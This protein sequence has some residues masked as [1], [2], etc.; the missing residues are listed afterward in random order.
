MNKP[1]VLFPMK[2]QLMK[3]K[4]IRRIPYYEGAKIDIR[5]LI[6]L[7]EKIRMENKITVGRGKIIKIIRKPKKIDTKSQKAVEL[8][9]DGFLTAEDLSHI[10]FD[11]F[12]AIKY[13]TEEYEYFQIRWY[14]D[15]CQTFNPVLPVS[16][17]ENEAYQQYFTYKSGGDEED[18]KTA[19]S[20]FITKVG[21]SRAR[22][23]IL[24]KEKGIDPSDSIEN[25]MDVTAEKSF[26]KLLPNTVKLFTIKN[27]S[28]TNGIPF[29]LKEL[30]VAINPI[31]DNLGISLEELSPDS[32]SWI[33]DFNKA[34]EV[35][36]GVE[37]K[38]SNQV[39]QISTAD[40][41]MVVGFS[42][43][44][45]CDD[46][47]RE[48]F[49]RKKAAGAFE[50][51]KQDS[52]TNNSEDEM[53]GYSSTKSKTDEFIR[54]MS[55]ETSGLTAVNILGA[56]FGFDEAKKKEA[57]AYVKNAE[58]L[59][60]TYAMDAFT[61]IY[62]GC[63][64][65]FWKAKLEAHRYIQVPIIN[66]TAGGTIDITGYK[67]IVNPALNSIAASLHGSEFTIHNDLRCYV[68]AR[69]VIPPVLIDKNP[70][71]I[72]P[73]RSLPFW[74]YDNL[75]EQ[76][77]LS[78]S[79]RDLSD[80]FNRKGFEG[81]Y[82]G[83]TRRYNTLKSISD[84]MEVNTRMTPIPEK[85]YTRSLKDGA[86]RFANQE[87]VEM[88]MPIVQEG[89]LEVL[90]EC[91]NEVNNYFQKL[92][93]GQ[94]GVSIPII[95]DESPMD[96][97]SVLVAIV[98]KSLFRMKELN[99]SGDC[100]PRVL[101]MLNQMKKAIELL[102]S[103]RGPSLKEV[104]VLVKETLDIFS[105]RY[106]AWMLALSARRLLTTNREGESI[107]RNSLV[108]SQIPNVP[109]I[110]QN[111]TGVFGWLENP[112]NA[113]ST[114]N[115]D[116]YYQTPSANQTVAAAMI[117]N[118]SFY[119]EEGGNSFKVN[120]SSLRYKE[121][122]WFVEGLQKGF[123]RAELLGM[124]LERLLHD[125][126]LDRL[127]YK[128]RSYYPLDQASSTLKCSF[129]VNGEAFVEDSSLQGKGFSSADLSHLISL[130]R[131][132]VELNDCVT[133]L[134][135]SE[136]AYNVAAGNAEMANA[137]LSAFEN[138]LPAP[139]VGMAPTVRTGQA[140]MQRVIIPI[141]GTEAEHGEKNP[142][143]IAEPS[144][145]RL[146]DTVLNEFGYGTTHMK[147]SVNIRNKDVSQVTV[148]DVFCINPL[149]DLGLSAFD[150]V[151]GGQKELES[152][153]RKFILRALHAKG[154]DV[155][156]A[157]K[158]DN[159]ETAFE[160]KAY[161]LF[162]YVGGMDRILDKA[163]ALHMMIKSSKPIGWEDIAVSKVNASENFH[164]RLESLKTLFARL[165]RLGNSYRTELDGLVTLRESLQGVL[166]SKNI[167]SMKQ[168][169]QSQIDSIITQINTKLDLFVKYG[170]QEANLYIDTDV[171]SL[172][173]P[174]RPIREI[175]DVL[176][177][178]DR[179]PFVTKP[180]FDKPIHNIENTIEGKITDIFEDII[181]KYNA[182]IIQKLDLL[183]ERLRSRKVQVKLQETLKHQIS[184]TV[185]I[186]YDMQMD[187]FVSD[188]GVISDE[189]LKSLTVNALLNKVQNQLK[190]WTAGDAMTILP[191]FTSP[192][193]R[194]VM[195][196]SSVEQ[197]KTY[198]KVRKNIL[199]LVSL[200]EQFTKS[201][202]HSVWEPGILE[203]MEAIKSKI[204]KSVNSTNIAAVMNDLKDIKLD[205]RNSIDLHY[206]ITQDTFAFTAG[207]PFTG[208]KIDE[209]SDFIHSKTEVTGVGFKC[210]T[211][212]SQAPNAIL[213]AVP[214]YQYP[215]NS[216]GKWTHVHL[217]RH[218]A[219]TLRMMFIRTECFNKEIPTTADASQPGNENAG[220][221]DNPAP[222]L[223]FKSTENDP[224]LR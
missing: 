187:R 153:A 104:E 31:P 82:P 169:L 39:S 111:L 2:L 175:S 140:L 37:V 14:P 49:M 20:E 95:Y 25:A 6:K 64:G 101:E 221:L 40:W 109:C 212:K 74:D 129:L 149:S 69:G 27:V 157:L 127:L 112:G 138:K 155:D 174:L 170:F 222:V 60:Q 33:N 35:G 164:F 200:T 158:E 93:S 154:Q 150:I 99:D 21:F 181:P 18:E 87:V 199:S 173:I 182:P 141:S 168:M 51:I 201:L 29:E 103:D 56:V 9:K 185:T 128:L 183:I 34:V 176:R 106:D 53:S 198:G 61:L 98:K 219:E 59:D 55:E 71:G 11:I 193:S 210:Q 134:F 147:A 194:I 197:L 209:W 145:S 207:M 165:E 143:C 124:R 85:L 7:S 86:Q 91:I 28:I 4:G 156:G 184:D 105:P 142:R 162:D 206:L 171:T 30:S 96:A 72:L 120:L 66:A 136:I 57:F 208:L 67:T 92:N 16:D 81:R 22:H 50:I 68:S 58:S 12:D 130:Q 190:E 213:I 192:Q 80:L 115:T 211:A 43:D 152:L 97:D 3:K 119:S 63:T 79:M 17:K 137:W 215:L 148:L 223:F 189:A 10:D 108:A 8:I 23:I 83:I 38:E 89:D 146:S 196:V 118:A 178:L 205:G 218:L 217:A 62:P 100:K 78:G 117:R 42:G 102:V 161:I 166:T 54:I 122:I 172:S 73:I 114:R 167:R 133:D 41:L 90:R 13:R 216:D 163:S 77:S 195:G 5:D 123:S 88:T 177:P 44:D 47:I 36:M 121:A 116:G 15:I 224:L 125:L 19:L 160:S 65:E 75:N 214:E 32:Q 107:T 139:K 203:S 188:V 186:S 46:L 220:F 76:S 202:S 179:N 151:L 113:P 144:L 70:Y 135:I 26:F 131:K 24:A 126:S 110:N 132:I 94:M 191:P 84:R 159:P 204:M 45:N 1:V 48:L 52:P 180:G